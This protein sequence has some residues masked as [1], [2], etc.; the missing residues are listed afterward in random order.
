MAFLAVHDL[1]VWTV[2]SGMICCSSHI[3]VE[4]QSVMSGEN[5][6]RAVTK[7]LEHDFS[8]AHTTIQVEVGGCEPNDMYCV[9]KAAGHAAGKA[10]DHDEHDSD[11]QSMSHEH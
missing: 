2:G 4:E 1:H 7:K 9:M 3:T 5:V 6:L 10:H 11:D 8:I